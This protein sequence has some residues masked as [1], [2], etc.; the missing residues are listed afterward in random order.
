MCQLH[1]RATV[2]E[3]AELNVAQSRE[4]S[5]P[6]FVFV[7]KVRELRGIEEGLERRRRVV[8]EGRRKKRRKNKK[9][10]WYKGKRKPTRGATPLFSRDYV[11]R[12]S[13]TCFN[14]YRS[15]G[16]YLGHAIRPFSKVLRALQ[17]GVFTATA[18][19]FSQDRDANR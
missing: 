6:L 9:N 16:A 8:S 17:C 13:D 14:A 5:L 19:E 12:V 2:G 3:E 18:V 1:P 7:T 11:P 10:Q 4:F 15:T